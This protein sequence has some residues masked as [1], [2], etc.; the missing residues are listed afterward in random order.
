M[1]C[2]GFQCSE[3]GTKFQSDACFHI[4]QVDFS[5]FQ[6]FSHISQVDLSYFSGRFLIFS[7]ISMF[8]KYI[9]HTSHIYLSYFPGRFVIFVSKIVLFQLRPLHLPSGGPPLER[10]QQQHLSN[11]MGPNLGGY[12]TIWGIVYLVSGVFGT[13]V[14]R[15]LVSGYLGIWHMGTWICS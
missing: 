9:C 14:S 10:A 3:E 4:S 6:C 15:Y 11:L 12:I 8:L 13:W 7:A 5:Y 1:R 2:L